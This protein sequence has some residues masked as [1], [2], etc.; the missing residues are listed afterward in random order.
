MTSTALAAPRSNSHPV[1]RDRPS[2][3]DRDGSFKIADLASLLA[4]Y[5][6]STGQ[7]QKVRHVV[8]PAM[9][10]ERLWSKALEARSESA[11]HLFPEEVFEQAE[12]QTISLDAADAR[13]L[14]L[15]AM[16][17]ATPTPAALAAIRLMGILAEDGHLE[18][19][20]VLPQLRDVLSNEDPQRRHQAVKAIWQA[21]AHDAL[22]HLHRRLQREKSD[23]VLAVIG[24]A[25]AVLER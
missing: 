6:S 14:G 7:F 16:D 4:I 23:A 12:D 5:Q 19:R 2:T 25:I 1:I 9:K 22:P 8:R 20:T 15:A 21:K 24:R 13:F 17:P 18:M 10:L 3:R 11:W